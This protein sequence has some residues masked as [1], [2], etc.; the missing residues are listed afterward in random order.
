MNKRKIPKKGRCLVLS[1]DHVA[2][3]LMEDKALQIQY[4]NHKDGMI[5]K[6]YGGFEIYEDVFAPEYDNTLNKIPYGSATSGRP[7]SVVFHVGSTAKARGSV[8]RYLSKAEDNPTMR[9]TTV[10]FRLW[11]ICIPTRVEGQAA[12]V[13]GT[14]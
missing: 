8:T 3:L 1:P 4:Q 12:I 14:V 6:N 11:F 10:G 2:D 13:S 5:A 9:E 7:A